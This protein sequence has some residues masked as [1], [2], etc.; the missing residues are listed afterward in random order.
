MR[1]YFGNRSTEA[2]FQ[3]TIIKLGDSKRGGLVHLAF[4]G[5]SMALCGH[6]LAWG[7]IIA[8]SD[9]LV[10]CQV[11]LKKNRDRFTAFCTG[12]KP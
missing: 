4:P 1:K 7:M 3:D 12:L 5:A 2:K 9:A 6:Y 10:T 11:C 8:G